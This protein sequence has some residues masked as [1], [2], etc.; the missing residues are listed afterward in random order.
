MTLYVLENGE[1]VYSREQAFGG[2]DLTSSLSQVSDMS[3]DEVERHKKSNELPDELVQGYINPFKQTTAQQ[4]SR[5]I[6]F[7]YSSWAV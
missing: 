5:S 7:Y 1:V 6:Q 3:I 2:N 4:I